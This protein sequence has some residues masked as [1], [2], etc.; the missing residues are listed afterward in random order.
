[1]FTAAIKYSIK[2][3]FVGD[4]PLRI[5]IDE[6]FL[7]HRTLKALK[8]Q[9]RP[10]GEIWPLEIW[11]RLLIP[12]LNDEFFSNHFVKRWIRGS[13]AVG[14]SVDGGASARVFGSLISWLPAKKPP[15]VF[16]GA[17]ANDVSQLMLNCLNPSP[18]G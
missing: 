3:G 5:S 16:V 10:R 13:P 8:Y 15:W 9:A 11:K 6:G 2:R 17:T 18:I 1:L 12:H 7:S 4:L 14:V